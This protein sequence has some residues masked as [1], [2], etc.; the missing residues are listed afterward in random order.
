MRGGSGTKAQISR[1][2][3]KN[4]KW[5]SSRGGGLLSKVWN[6]TQSRKKGNLLLRRMLLFLQVTLRK[7]IC[8]AAIEGT[9][10]W[11][12]DPQC[13]VHSLLNSSGRSWRFGYVGVMG[14]FGLFHF[15]S[16]SML[17][18]LF[19]TFFKTHIS[20]ISRWSPHFIMLSFS[21]FFSSSLSF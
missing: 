16:L 1:R 6:K 21:C 4:P 18:K 17:G 10:S 11:D 7:H 14:S 2:L 13:N 12:T 9:C 5:G 15:C 3:L 19:L 8:S 20:R